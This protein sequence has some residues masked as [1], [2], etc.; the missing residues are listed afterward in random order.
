MRVIVSGGGTAG[1]INPALSIAKKIKEKEKDSEI[2]FV[3]TPAGMENRLVEKAGFP[4][5]HVEV[6]GFQRKLTLKNIK[7]AFLAVTSVSKAKKILREFRPDVV[8]G[9]GGYV[10]WPVL[11]AAEKLGVPTLVHEQNA[12]PGLTVSK[13]SKFADVVCYSFEGSEKNFPCKKEKLVLTGN[14]VGP[15]V[16]AAKK[17]ECRRKL[18]ISAPFLLSYGG[19][20]GAS[21][22]NE[23]M[24]EFARDY[25]MKKPIF[26]THAFGAREW[27]KWCEKEKEARITRFGNVRFREYIDDMPRQM[28]AADLVIC[29]AGAITLAELAVL[30]KP[31]VL[32]PSPNVVNDHQ[33]KNARLFEEAGA[34]VLLPEGEL[35]TEKLIG[36]VSDLLFSP[37]K[38]RKMSSAMKKMAKPDADEKIFAEIAKLTKHRS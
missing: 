20:L 11:R 33:T 22:I 25:S 14:P 32:I 35:S 6:K 15:E 27:D 31:A 12:I 26:H 2:L 37:E 21:A 30:G 16:I 24:F 29:R 36:I 19:S 8:V 23:A 10:C 38:L 3:G 1:H 5:R 34:A 4:I 18:G 9:T 17:D 7:S 28:A 13:L